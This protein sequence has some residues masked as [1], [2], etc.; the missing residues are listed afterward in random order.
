MSIGLSDTGDTVIKN[1]TVTATSGASFITSST[2]DVLIT[3]MSLTAP[4]KG[5]YLV[6]F[7]CQSAQSNNN[8]QNIFTVYYNG[9]AVTN[10]SFQQTHAGSSMESVSIS[11]LVDVT[12]A[13]TSIDIMLRVSG[14]T[15]TITNRSLTITRVL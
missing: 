2:S 5:K 12:T 6:L 8:R 13:S 1:T 14:N 3:G 4:V 10:M 11:G 9:V 15:A 7:T